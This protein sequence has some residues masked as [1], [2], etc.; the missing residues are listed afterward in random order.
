MPPDL[1]IQNIASAQTTKDYILPDSLD[2]T[3]KCVTASFDGTSAAASFVGEVQIIDSSGLVMARCPCS[4]TLAAGAS[5]DI[6]WFRLNQP[7][8][9]G[10]AGSAYQTLVLGT[11][12]IRSYWPLTEPSGVTWADLGPSTHNL[13]IFGSP[14]LGTSPLITTGA[15][16]TV[17]QPGGSA[18]NATQ[19]GS[20]TTDYGVWGGD[21]S[22]T[23]EAWI[24]CSAAQSWRQMIF[25][26]DDGH[27]QLCQLRIDTDGKVQWVTNDSTDSSQFAAKSATVV[28]TGSKFYLAGTHDGTLNTLT[29]Y[30]NGVSDGTAVSTSSWTGTA[31]GPQIAQQLI[32]GI[33]QNPYI[34]VVD[35]VAVYNRCLTAAEVAQHY[36]AGT[37]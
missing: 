25:A 28:T 36:T 16:G 9:S 13:A 7:Q 1:V 2:L 29:I 6:S 11:P 19:G 4:T 30:V 33:H 24:Q 35:E 21:G 17:S 8:T 32:S 5:A 3:L 34:G 18:L 15:S 27:F 37:T 10:S 14:A 20:N 12:N 31:P 22:V 23:V 26:L